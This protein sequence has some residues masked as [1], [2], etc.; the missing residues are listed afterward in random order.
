MRCVAEW[1]ARIA[2]RLGVVDDHVDLV[3]GLEG[4][5]LDRA[6]MH[7][8]HAELLLR[9]GDAEQRPVRPFDDA[10]IADLA[11]AL[12]IERRLVDDDLAALPLGQDLD[13]LAAGERALDDRLGLLGVVAEELG[14]ADLLLD[15]EPDAFG[16]RLARALP[17][18]ARLVLLASPWRR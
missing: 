11:A 6:R 16:C 12:A 8:Q 15:L 17:G 9:V 18:A 1:L 3:A 14:R 13:G 5:G 7:E 10:A 2:V 4:A